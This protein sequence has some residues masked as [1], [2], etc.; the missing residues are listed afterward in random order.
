MMMERS[1][2]SFRRLVEPQR[3]RRQQRCEL[4][5][6]RLMAQRLVVGAFSYEPQRAVV[7]PR[8]PARRAGH[9]EQLGAIAIQ[10]DEQLATHGCVGE[11]RRLL[12]RRDDLRG[13]TSRLGLADHL[14]RIAQRQLAVFEE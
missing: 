6:Q 11:L 1:T 2:Y 3:L 4:C 9:G 8:G 7:E 13:D 12:Q 5:V 10:R 14:G